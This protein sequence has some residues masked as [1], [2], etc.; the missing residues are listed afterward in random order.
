MKQKRRF[1]ILVQ[2]TN[3]FQGL[4]KL[5]QRKTLSSLGITLYQERRGSRGSLLPRLQTY[6]F[7]GSQNNT[8]FGLLCLYLISENQLSL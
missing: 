3:L 1:K 2:E 5:K 6:G 7:G 4:M 8:D